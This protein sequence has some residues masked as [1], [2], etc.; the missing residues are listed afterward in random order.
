MLVEMASDSSLL[1]DVIDISIFQENV[2]PTSQNLP[3]I[4]QFAT[5]SMTKIKFHYQLRKCWRKNN[6]LYIKGTVGSRNMNQQESWQ[7]IWDWILSMLDQEE[8]IINE[9]LLI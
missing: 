5:K 1:E 3:P 4:P 7:C 9:K 6:G 2:Y 8:Q